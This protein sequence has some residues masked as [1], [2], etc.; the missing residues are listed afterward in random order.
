MEGYKHHMTAI[1]HVR[2]YSQFYTPARTLL[3]VLDRCRRLR[4]TD[5]R[6]HIFAMFGMFGDFKSELPVPD[7]RKS[8]QGVFA[9]M[10][11]VFLDNMDTLDILQHVTNVE[12]KSDIPSWVVDFSQRPKF[13]IPTAH[14]VYNAAADSPSLY[15]L[16]DD[17]KELQLLGL[18]VDVLEKLDKAPIEGYYNPYIPKKAILGYQQ[19]IRV[20]RSITEYPTG[21]DPEEVLWRTMCWN[22]DMSGR[23]PAADDTGIPF[24][25]F[26]NA[27]MSG[28]DIEVIDKEIL[29]ED[30]CGFN[31]IC[32]HSMP[33]CITEDGYLASVPWTAEKGDRVYVFSGSQVPILLRKDPAEEHYRFIGI[34]YVHGIM[35][36]EAF[37]DD[38]DELEW[39]SIR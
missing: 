9:D 36:G 23:F 25:H 38:S 5:Q 16:S 26:S 32:V 10:T 2:E 8:S 27:L 37:P 14:D 1:M 19:D 24:E 13:H 18:C 34:C 29:L 35:E 21:E 33:L 11:Q 31:D 6:D 22:L 7:Y 20:G 39:I 4:S 28:K 12:A 30:A 3:G 17:G 15:K